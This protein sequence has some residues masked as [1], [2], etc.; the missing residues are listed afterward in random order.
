M[1]RQYEAPTII[2]HQA[3]LINKVAHQAVAGHRDSI[4][5]VPVSTLIERYGSPLFVFDEHHIR[6]RYREVLSTIRAHYPDT[7]ISWSYKTNYLG[8]ICSIYHQEGARAEVVSRMEYDMA[9]RLGVPGKD[10]LF[11]GPGKRREDLLLAVEEGALIHIDHLDEMVMIE[12]VADELG[13]RP[14]VAIR[15]NMDTGI[16]PQWQR[17]G[18]N[19][20]NGEAWRAAQRLV[21]GGKLELEGVHCHIGTFMLEPNAYYISTAKLLALALRLRDELNVTVSYVDIGGGFASSNT[22]HAQYMPGELASPG[23]DRFATAIGSA[24][25]ESQ[26]VREEHPRLMLETGRALIDEAGSMIS[27]VIGRKYLPTGVRAL[28]LDAGVSVLFTSWWYNLKVTPAQPLSGSTQPTTFFGPLCMNID[29]VKNSCMFPDMR[30][31]ER[32]IV[33]PVGAYNVTQWMQFIEY[34]P[35][36]ALVTE[37]GGTELIRERESLQDVIGRERLPEHLA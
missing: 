17:F 30:N 12:Q 33:S 9:R 22:L 28:I 37:T 4:G 16:Y 23:F 19:Y 7:D 13:M 11:N 10:I 15:V 26:F 27:T 1:K 36:V 29:V 34:R 5:G 2:R 32:V 21:A 31:G 18:F 35:A 24:M 6:T 8:A 20:D 25:N 3:G 14:R